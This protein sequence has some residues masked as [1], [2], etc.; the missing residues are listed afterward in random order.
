M[1]RSKVVWH[2]P[3]HIQ[4]CWYLSN[5]FI[6]L[7]FSIEGDK[8]QRIFFIILFLSRCSRKYLEWLVVLQPWTNLPW[9]HFNARHSNKS[10]L[11]NFILE[12][13]VA[14]EVWSVWD[15]LY[16]ILWSFH[17]KEEWNLIWYFILWYIWII[18]TRFS[19]HTSPF[20]TKW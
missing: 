16:I 13:L 11:I 17:N 15:I 4:V 6:F 12:C 3:T 10:K 20:D 7:G 1:E 2:I 8:E 19:F 18:E 9:Y 5:S 14:S